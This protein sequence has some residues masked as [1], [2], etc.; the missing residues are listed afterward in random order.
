M[1][2]A[3]KSCAGARMI[4]VL[5]LGLLTVLLTGYLLFALLVPE[6]F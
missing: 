6:K 1:S 5:W 4:D 2:K 3:A